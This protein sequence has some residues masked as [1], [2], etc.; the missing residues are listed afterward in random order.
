MPDVFNIFI[1]VHMVIF[2]NFSIYITLCISVNVH[3]YNTYFMIYN[4][5]SQCILLASLYK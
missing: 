1:F 2:M 3:V 5:F 4:A